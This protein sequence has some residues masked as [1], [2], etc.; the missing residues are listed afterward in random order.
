MPRRI[1]S[2]SGSSPW[3]VWQAPS[4]P[5]RV[6][7]TK[8]PERRRRERAFEE[9]DQR[10]LPQYEVHRRR[11]NKLKQAIAMCKP[12]SAC[13]PAT[14]AQ[15]YS[16]LGTVYAGGMSKPDEATAAFAEALKIDPSVVPN[17]DMVSPDVDR[18]GVQEGQE[19]RPR[20][21]SS[22][23]WR[24]RRFDARAHRQ[25]ET[26]VLRAATCVLTRP[27]CR[28]GDADAG[29]HLCRA[30]RR[31]RAPSG[32]RSTISLGAAASGSHSR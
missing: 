32:C 15:L 21:G 30:P 24:Q 12:S 20:G 13:T 17:P 4:L 31:A 9:G 10:G 5:R 23:R 29:P 8:R 27:S 1:L 22:R 6:D 26:P 28:T 7:R 25:V 2:R 18:G 3:S 11:E 16:N 19:G 14:R